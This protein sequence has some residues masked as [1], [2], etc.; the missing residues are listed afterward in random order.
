MVGSDPLIQTRIYAGF[1][2]GLRELGAQLQLI[3]FAERYGL[4]PFFPAGSLV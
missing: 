4:Y 3:K 2:S 1:L